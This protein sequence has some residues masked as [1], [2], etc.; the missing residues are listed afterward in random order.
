[1]HRVFLSFAS[2]LFVF[3]RGEGILEQ[4]QSG[5]GEIYATAVVCSTDL[6]EAVDEALA[7]ELLQPVVADV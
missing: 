3:L 5:E 6:F 7:V 1:M 2:S 4:H